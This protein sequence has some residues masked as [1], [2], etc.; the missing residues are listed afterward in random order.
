M[1]TTSLWRIEGGLNRVIEYIENP[2][3]TQERIT[4]TKDYGGGEAS[5]VSVLD[6]VTRESATDHTQLVTAINCTLQNVTEEMM[7]TKKAFGKTGGTVAYHGY[8]SFKEGEVTP[9]QAHLIG[10]LLA[11]ELWG[12]RY[13]VVVAT[14]VDKE[15]H[16]HNHFLINTVSFVDGKKFHRTKQDYLR[17]Q[18]VSDRLCRENG[19]SV[20]RHPEDGRGK[21]YGEWAAEQKGKPTHRRMIRQDIDRAI[22]ASLTEREFFRHLEEMGYEFKLRSSKGEELLRPSLKPKD[23]QR[24]FRFDRL[25]E[26]YDLEEIRYRILEN[27]RREPVIPEENVAFVSRYSLCN[28]NDFFVFGNNSYKNDQNTIG[29]DAY[30]WQQHR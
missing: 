12:D 7:K 25:G 13:E 6:Y 24:F 10:E 28:V 22:K 2:E 14:H 27:I 9:Q 26:G 3:K 4:E 17:M 18:Q 8:Q 20:V 23:A 19:L 5:I 11:Q 1:A 29:G 15:S 30:E 16:I 21:N